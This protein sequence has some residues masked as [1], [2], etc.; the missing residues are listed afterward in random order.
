MGM[1]IAIGLDDEQRVARIT[2]RCRDHGL[3]IGEE[4]D[5]LNMFPALILDDKTAGEAL[6]ILARA[7]RYRR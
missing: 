3:L 2:K 1:A 5:W 6:D 4:E 7:A